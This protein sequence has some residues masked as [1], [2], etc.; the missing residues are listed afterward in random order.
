MAAGHIEG[1][2]VHTYTI[3]AFAMGLGSWLGFW[4]VHLSK[5]LPAYYSW[6]VYITMLVILPQLKVYGLVKTENTLVY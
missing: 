2:G 6:P 4:F 1:G 5:Y 3:A